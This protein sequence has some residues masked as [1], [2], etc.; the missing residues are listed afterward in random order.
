MLV[1]HLR[2]CKVRTADN[3]HMP[4]ANASGVLSFISN[5]WSRYKK[6]NRLACLSFK[7]IFQVVL[8]FWNYFGIGFGRAN[9]ISL[10]LY[11]VINYN[12]IIYRVIL[13]NLF[14]CCR[15]ANFKVRI[16]KF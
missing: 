13:K 3:Y 12:I 4:I 10:Q 15:A 9:S 5:A 1:G 16:T 8:L 6:M 11:R 2:R 14:L 7:T